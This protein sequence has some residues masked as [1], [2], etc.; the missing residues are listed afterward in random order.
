MEW[1]NRLDGKIVCLD[2][3][4]IIYYMESELHIEK[5]EPLFDRIS[6]GKLNAV[7][8]TITLLEVLVQPY[9]KGDIELANSYR[10]I[11]LKSKNFSVVPLVEEI[12]EKAAE[13]RAEYNIKTPDAIQL[14]TA[15]LSN[16]T[17]FLTNDFELG[18]ID[19]L[20]V[21]ILDDL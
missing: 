12:S 7:T 5:L 3:V 10:D 21:I 8:S 15:I 2:T 9:R 19:D 17:A 16:A 6:K 20:D 1:L 18:K 14:S 13:L 4:P 11:L